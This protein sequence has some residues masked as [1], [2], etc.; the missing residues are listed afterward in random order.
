MG[1]YF[2]NIKHLEVVTKDDAAQ[3]IMSERHPQ[4]IYKY[5][6]MRDISSQK[7]LRYFSNKCWDDR[8]KLDM[9]YYH[10]LVRQREFR[11]YFHKQ[12]IQIKVLPIRE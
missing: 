5:W 8:P 1:F 11:N 12:F 10:V 6:Y 7:S 3:L 4:D 2:K 9:R